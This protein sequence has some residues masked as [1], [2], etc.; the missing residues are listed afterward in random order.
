MATFVMSETDEWAISEGRMK[1]LHHL[2]L[3]RHTRRWLARSVSG[4]FDITELFKSL[5]SWIVLAPAICIGPLRTLSFSWTILA[6]VIYLALMKGCMNI[7]YTTLTPVFTAMFRNITKWHFTPSQA[8]FTFNTIVVGTVTGSLAGLIFLKMERNAVR[9]RMQREH[10]SL[11]PYLPLAF[12]ASSLFASG[13]LIAFGMA[14]KMSQPISTLAVTTLAITGTTLGVLTAEASM[15]RMAKADTTDAINF[16][17]SLAGGLFPL[18]A[19]AL[20][21]LPSGIVW[22]N[23]IFGVAALFILER[24]WCWYRRGEW[25]TSDMMYPRSPRLEGNTMP[26]YVE[27]GA[28]RDYSS[29]VIK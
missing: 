15:Y 5:T 10:L 14:V 28:S 4:S 6:P 18:I 2:L 16:L 20:Y 17:G 19:Q 12:A 22:T 23:A 27:L 29:P 21:L 8:G 3:S 9:K 25:I 26:D 1:K 7:L 13:G 24:V 11:L